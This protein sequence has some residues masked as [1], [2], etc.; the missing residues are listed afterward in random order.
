[1]A[2]ICFAHKNKA[3]GTRSNICKECHCQY[4]K[5]HYSKNRKYYVDKAR[6]NAP[7][8]IENI[9]RKMM[10]YLDGKSCIDC[11][12]SD[13]VVLEFDHKNPEQKEYSISE[14]SRRS[15]KRTLKEIDK[16]VIR[17]A[18]CHR[19]KTARELGWYRYLRNDSMAP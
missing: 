12:E 18:N 6:R 2:L 1:M 3:K 11:H 4:S 17:C 13:P 8:G 19:R 10:E 16:C 5:N 14:I 7:K 9:R 15:W